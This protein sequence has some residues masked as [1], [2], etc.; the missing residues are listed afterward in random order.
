MQVWIKNTVEDSLSENWQL[1]M[2]LRTENIMSVIS[3]DNSIEHPKG[4]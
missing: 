2:E 1:A 3:D 4:L